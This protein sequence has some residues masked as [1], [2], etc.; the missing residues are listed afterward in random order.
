MSDFLLISYNHHKFIGWHSKMSDFICSRESEALSPRWRLSTIA[1]PPIL[2]LNFR[3]SPNLDA[4]P[5][6]RV[7]KT[8]RRN[9]VA[10]TIYHKNKWE[11]TRLMNGYYVVGVIA[12][13]FPRCEVI[14]NIV[15]KEDIAYHV[16]ISDISH[17]TCPNFTK[18]SSLVFGKEREMGV[19]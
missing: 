7:G 17:C 15:F 12:I 16:I 8:L 2:W 18:W 10:P 4:H 19:L 9:L 14:I 5:T 3:A 11:I 13:A 1:I 6:S